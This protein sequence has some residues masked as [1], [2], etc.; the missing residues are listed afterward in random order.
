M[1]YKTIVKLLIGLIISAIF[2]YFTIYDV[3]FSNIPKGFE[4]ARYD[5][6]FP[7]LLLLLSLPVLR[8]MRW[9][10]ILSPLV[11]VDL[12][13]L[14]PVTCIGFM[15]ITLIPMRAGEIVRPSLISIKKQIPLSSTV[16]TVLVER[17]I[18]ILALVTILFL[19]LVVLP[20]P[21]WVFASG[22]VFLGI[23]LLLVVIMALFVVKTEESTKFFSPVFKLLPVKLNARINSLIRTFIDGFKVI[24]DPKKIV[25]ILFLTLLIWGVSGLAIYTLFFFYNFQIPLVGAFAVMT[26]TG[27]GISLP[28][29]SG[30]LGNF[31]FACILALS[32]FNIPKTDALAFS[33]VYYML[34]IIGVN[35][36]LGLA[37]LPF[38]KISFQEIKS[39]RNF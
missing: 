31:Q 14:F 25:Y 32:L 36:I 29:V 18:D 8:S 23:S 34:A 19:I 28:S 35:V 1:K 11:K 13:T 6:L 38:E 21:A 12:K 4:R 15:A 17:V 37:F 3:D 33:M 16:A 27:L 10:A 2:I 24:S 7:S 5:F 20:L 39:F 22:A 30:F 26:L 9:G